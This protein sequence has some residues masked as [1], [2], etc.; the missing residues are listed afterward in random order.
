MEEGG[1]RGAIRGCCGL[2]QTPKSRQLLF[3]VF[4]LCLAL[5]KDGPRLMPDKKSKR[6]ANTTQVTF[7]PPCFLSTFLILCCC[8]C[9]FFRL[10]SVAWRGE[11]QFLVFP[12]STVATAK[13]NRI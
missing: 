7:V 8:C 4:I 13:S 5:G 1:A 9:C 6:H 11:G 10:V 3:F 12:F 2:I